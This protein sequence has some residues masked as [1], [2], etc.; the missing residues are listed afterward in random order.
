MNIWW[1]KLTMFHL[2]QNNPAGA[3]TASHSLHHLC[4]WPWDE[5]E[6]RLLCHKHGRQV[7]NELPCQRWYFVLPLVKKITFLTTT[8][9]ASW[10]FSIHE[11]TRNYHPTTAMTDKHKDQLTLHGYGEVEEMGGRCGWVDV[12]V[13]G[14]RLK[15][16]GVCSRVWWEGQGFDR[17]M[18]AEY[19]VRKAK[20]GMRRWQEVKGEDM[21]GG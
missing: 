21:D 5:C 19:K 3:S 10:S 20:W 16:V 6:M 12:D 7:K 4:R 2:R 8:Q 9:K 17:L 11:H 14:R 13:T 15:G 18:D 1:D